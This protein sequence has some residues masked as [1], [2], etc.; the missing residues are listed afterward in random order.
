M[1]LPSRRERQV[2]DQ[3]VPEPTDLPRTDSEAGLPIPAPAR[4]PVTL[5]RERQRAVARLA[6]RS[7]TIGPIRVA[8]VV[9]VA[10]AAA[11]TGAAVAARLLR[12]RVMEGRPGV[13]P[14]SWPATTADVL[15]PAL[16][17]RYTRW[18][19]HWSDQP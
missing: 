6:A 5:R 8:S 7:L 17:L 16:H 13:P 15:R 19:I 18:E 9:G 1:E 14:P 12:P 4:L 3:Q 2:S 10:A 11:A